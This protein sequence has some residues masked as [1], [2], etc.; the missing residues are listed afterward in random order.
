MHDGNQNTHGAARS[1]I[2]VVV[3]YGTAYVV[4]DNETCAASM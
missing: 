2:R 4:N 1:A 3:L